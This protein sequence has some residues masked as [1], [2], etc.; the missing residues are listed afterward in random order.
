MV[1]RK[2]IIQAYN[3]AIIQR[4]RHQSH[5]DRQQLGKT[6]D[7]EFLEMEIPPNTMAIGKR[8]SEILLPE[9]CLIISIQRGRKLYFAHGYSTLEAGDELTMIS[10]EGSAAMVRENLLTEE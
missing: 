7:S 4:A 6:I 10:S 5:S 2:N 1:R 8:V 9:D 3:T